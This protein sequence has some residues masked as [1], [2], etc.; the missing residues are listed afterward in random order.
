MFSSRQFVLV[1][2]CL[3]LC[4]ALY[5]VVGL[6]RDVARAP[7]ITTALLK[8]VTTTS[9]SIGGVVLTAQVADT[10]ASREQGLSGTNA[11]DEI[12]A[13][14]FTFNTPGL[15][16]FWMKDMNYSIDMIWLDANKQVVF[17]KQHATPESYPA[18]FGPTKPAQYVLE[19]A[20]G[21]TEKY[22]VEVGDKVGFAVGK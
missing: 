20:D 9:V 17:T 3:I 8:S 12:H 14:L 13:M 1:V 2:C 4:A 15:Y 16:T 6:R 5:G 21:F 7:V 22:H 18:T 19:V 10:E 11:L